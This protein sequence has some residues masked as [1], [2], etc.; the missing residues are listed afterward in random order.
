ME[1]QKQAEQQWNKI[2]RERIN[3][4]KEAPSLD[5]MDFL[6]RSI[7]RRSKEREKV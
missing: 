2:R 1:E 3:I 7:N 6:M 5:G 4:L